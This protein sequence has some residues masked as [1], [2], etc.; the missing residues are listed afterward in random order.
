MYRVFESLDELN[1]HL[2]QAYGVPMTSNAMVPRNEMLALLDELRNALPV[3]MDDAQDVLDKQDEIIHGAEDRASQTIAD[4]N[5][6]ADDIVGGARG[7]ADAML[8]DAQQRSESM[9]AQAEDEARAL[10]DNAR[11]E[12]DRTI[13]QANDTY[14]RTVADGQAEQDRLVSEA[15]VVPVSYTH[16]TLPTICSV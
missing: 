1:R 5:A 2:E 8:A 13:A 3:E 15:E 4:A 9:I 16:L 6:E 10:V 7:D 11:S 12:A 14:E